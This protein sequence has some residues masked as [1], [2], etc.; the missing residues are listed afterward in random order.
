MER[1]AGMEAR[2]GVSFVL[3]CKDK[4]GNVLKTIPVRGALSLPIFETEPE[5]QP[6]GLDRSK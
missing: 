6:D 5:E 2:M 3:E 4:D 1:Q